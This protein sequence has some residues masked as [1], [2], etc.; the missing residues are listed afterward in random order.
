MTE[1]E[2][3]TAAAEAR[4]ERAAILEWCAGMSRDE[5]E[6]FA[7]RESEAFRHACEVKHVLGLADIEDRR[8]YLALVAEKR[9]AEAEK[10][11]ADDVRASLNIA[12]KRPGA[13]L[14]GA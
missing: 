13:S 2:I 9:G 12:K 1:A 5:A 3:S 11:L 8:R 7:G 14:D 4:E 10:R 6:L